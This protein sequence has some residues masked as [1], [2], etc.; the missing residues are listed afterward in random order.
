MKRSTGG[1]LPEPGDPAGLSERA[2]AALRFTLKLPLKLAGRLATHAIQILLAIFIVVLHPQV[3]WLAGLIAR[4]SIVQD[5]IRPALR[6]FSVHIYEPYFAFLARLPPYWATFSIA[7]PLAIL[8]PAKFIATILIAE[9]PK[10]GIMLW[11]A[12]QGLSLVLIDRTWASVRPQSRK[13]WLV[14][15]L[16]AWLWLNAAYGK[17]WIKTSAVYRGALRLRNQSRRKAFSIWSALV[18]RRRRRKF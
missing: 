9:R 1:K 3:K 2:G 17:Y 7:L 15:R 12:L 8:E 5:Y 18:P 6:G 10:T 11:L 16:H 13:L 4:S 14:S